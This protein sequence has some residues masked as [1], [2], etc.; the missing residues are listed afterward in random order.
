MISSSPIKASTACT[1]PSLAQFHPST[2]KSTPSRQSLPSRRN[3]RRDIPRPREISPGEYNSVLSFG[4]RYRD[5][6]RTTSARRPI[7]NL[8]DSRTVLPRSRATRAERYRG[9]I[10][11]FAEQRHK[12]CA[13]RCL[14][15]P[16][17]V[18]SN[19]Q[20]NRE[21][22]RREIKKG[23]PRRRRPGV[24]RDADSSDNGN[25]NPRETG[26]R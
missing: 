26:S 25:S 9:E 20:G 3:L 1:L 21:W 19:I 24:W 5:N 16:A 10:K 23:A 22:S 18:K 2:R 15:S 7:T 12:R 4:V 17:L 8:N 6:D 11:S 13:P 14:T